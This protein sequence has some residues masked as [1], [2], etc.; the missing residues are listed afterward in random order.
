[1]EQVDG[2]HIQPVFYNL[3][4]GAT[5]I[6]PLMYISDVS[7]P[8]DCSSFKRTVILPYGNAQGEE[9]FSCL[10]FYRRTVCFYKQQC[11]YMKLNRFSGLAKAQTALSVLK[12]PAPLGKESLVLVL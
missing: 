9:L 1:M 12:P 3:Y 8:G 4:P 7:N 10:Y 2:S 11:M 5:V 6:H